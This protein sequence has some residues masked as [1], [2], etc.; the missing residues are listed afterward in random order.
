MPTTY[1]T[2]AR[3]VTDEKLVS[4]VAGRV[5]LVFYCL[6]FV[7]GLLG[8]EPRSS[9]KIEATDLFI[10]GNSSVIYVAIRKKNYRNVTNCHVIN[11]AIADLLFLTLSIPYTT[12]L[13]VHNVHPFGDTA[14]KIYTYLAYVSAEE[15]VRTKTN[16]ILFFEGIF[17]SHL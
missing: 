11:L 8:M 4:D 16:A 1:P 12:Y 14:C 13:G 3:N 7:F 6:I 10:L 15:L 5:L 17:A 2:M 9:E